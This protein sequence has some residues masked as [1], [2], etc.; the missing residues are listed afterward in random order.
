MSEESKPD[1][2]L[3]LEE[4]SAL[5]QS[6]G[7]TMTAEPC[8]RP[9]SKM[10][11]HAG[12]YRCTL[13]GKQRSVYR[14]KRDA[15]HTCEYSVGSGI[16]AR[17]A[18]EGCPVGI[19]FG[20]RWDPADFKAPRWRF[21]GGGVSLHQESAL[22]NVRKAFR[23]DLVDVFSALLRDVQGYEPDM[24]FR[25][26]CAEMLAQGI[27]DQKTNPADVLEMFESV[28]DASRFLHSIMD[29]ETFQRAQD[30]CNR[31]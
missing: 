18:A 2:V 31:T 13:R 27:A 29:D 17:F 23:P 5:V 15:T 16:L 28:R 6:L 10:D 24:T 20:S 21:R 11:A 3:A 14:D 22:R 7:V 25:A 1:H 19:E 12:H 4:L 26:W 30:A 8:E 9:G